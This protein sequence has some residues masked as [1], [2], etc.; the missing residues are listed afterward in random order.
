MISALISSAFA[1]VSAYLPPT[2]TTVRAISW[3][4]GGGGYALG[5]EEAHV[6]LLHAQLL[7]RIDQLVLPAHN[8]ETTTTMSACRATDQ[9]QGV[10]DRCKSSWKSRIGPTVRRKCTTESSEMSVEIMICATP[11][12]QAPAQRRNHER[13]EARLFF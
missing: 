2:T 11:Y 3:R 9:S 4:P 1:S 7:E 10:A 6:L 8:N 5:L 12:T 13:D